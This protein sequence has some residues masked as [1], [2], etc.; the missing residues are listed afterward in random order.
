MLLTK[1]LMLALVL[2]QSPFV[3]VTPTVPSAR[4]Q[5]SYQNIRLEDAIRDIARQA[6]LG[7]S[8]RSDLPDLDRVIAVSVNESAGSAVLRILSNTQLEALI[9]DAGNTLLLRRRAQ[10]AQDVE[11]GLHT[12]PIPI[13]EVVVT[14]GHFGIAYES[15]SKAQ[16]L[17]REQIQTLPQLGE[18]L[19]RAINRLPGMASNEYSAKITVRGGDDQSVLVRLDGMELYEPYHLKDFDGALSIIDVASIGGVDVITGGFGAEFGNRLTGVFDM[20]STSALSSRPGT[21]IGISL[22][23]ARF[24]S[25]GSF[26]NDNGLWLFSARRGYLDILLDLIGERARIDPTY[27]DLLGKLVYQLSPAHRVSVHGLR[28]GDHGFFE[29]DDGVGSI[30]S[31]YGSSYGWVTWDFQ[32]SDGVRASTQASFGKL[33]WRRNASEHGTGNDFDI[34]ESRDFSFYGVKQDWR[35]GT[36]HVFIKWGGEL[37]AGNAEYDY[38]NRI[39]R[40]RAEDG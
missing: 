28:A 5:A 25:Q 7:L 6:N 32:I 17:T 39:G 22:S 15:G 10:R 23:N 11:L 3:P 29:D 35:F 31:S 18:D 19:Y 24:M 38:F 4:V 37:R 27:Y 36:D 12:P 21:S 34:L 2:G 26:A 20:R 40:T 33:D 13:Q 9:S 30:T 16:A 14:P 1:S 8:Y